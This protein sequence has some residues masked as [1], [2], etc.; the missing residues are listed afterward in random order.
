MGGH[1]TATIIIGLGLIAIMGFAQQLVVSYHRKL[2][3]EEYV[4]WWRL[5]LGLEAVIW[6]VRIWPVGLLS[7]IV[8]VGLY[9]R[10]NDEIKFYREHYL[11]YHR[12]ID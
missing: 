11:P 5:T 10:L 7:L 6:G 4:W 12:V 2:A 1:Y 3:P 9:V 8:W